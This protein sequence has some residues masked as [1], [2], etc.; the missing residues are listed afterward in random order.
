MAKGPTS[1]KLG[2][3]SKKQIKFVDKVVE[4]IESG[5]NPNL[6]EAAL[7]SYETKSKAV[8]GQ[9]GYE[10]MNKPEVIEEIEDRLKRAGVS[11]QKNLENLARLA[12]ATP[13]KYTDSAILK[14]NI[15]IA[16]IY[17]HGQ[18]AGKGGLKKTITKT[19]TWD[20]AKQQVTKMVEISTELLR[21][22]E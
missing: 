2:K 6:T 5:E 3:L 20:E 18:G 14:A 9:I 21:D 11:E 12:N 22:A 17:G 4:Q 13:E 7:K 8:A 1:K 15:F 16:G 19:V 10:N